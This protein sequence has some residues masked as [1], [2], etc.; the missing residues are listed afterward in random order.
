MT[1]IGIFT[2][3]SP[4]NVIFTSNINS[5]LGD[6]YSQNNTFTIQC[7]DCNGDLGGSTWIDSC[8]NCVDGNTG[9]SPCIPFSPTVSVNLSN[10][11]CDSLAD[12]SISVSQ[13]PNEPDMSTSLFSSDGGSFAISTMSVG[14]TV[15]SATMQAGNFNFNTV[16]IVS[17]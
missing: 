11:N 1:L 13:D 17:P 6:V 9:N 8:G 7:N 3:P 16:L 4:S 5:E 15:G 2:N 14:D 12:L 10:T